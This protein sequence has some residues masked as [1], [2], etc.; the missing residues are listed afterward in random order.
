MYVKSQEHDHFGENS[1]YSYNRCRNCSSMANTLNTR[2]QAVTQKLSQMYHITNVEY[3]LCLQHNSLAIH[4]AAVKQDTSNLNSWCTIGNFWHSFSSHLKIWHSFSSRNLQ[5]IL[6]SVS[7]TDFE[8][9]VVLMPSMINSRE[10]C[11]TLNNVN[12]QNAIQLSAG[13]HRQFSSETQWTLVR[14]FVSLT[15]FVPFF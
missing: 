7:Q 1:K 9:V 15:H 4:K 5:E 13:P 6:L 11:H 10:S 2:T 3:I 12:S 14:T 8:F